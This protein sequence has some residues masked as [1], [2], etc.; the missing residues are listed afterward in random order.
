[1][2]EN[3]AHWLLLNSF[4]RW[5][6]APQG[7]T[8]TWNRGSD[9]LRLIV[10]RN[11]NFY[12]WTVKAIR[13]FKKSTISWDLPDAFGLPQRF[14]TLVRPDIA[15]CFI[16]CYF[17]NVHQTLS[18][19]FNTL[20]MQFSL[21]TTKRFSCSSGVERTRLVWSKRCLR[22]IFVSRWT[23]TYTREKRYWKQILFQQL[24]CL[25]EYWMWILKKDEKPVFLSH[26]INANVF[27]GV[28]STI[29][30]VLVKRS[31]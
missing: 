5:N 16:S 8:G 11:E 26:N 14:M 21:L 28:T 24:L 22:H 1:M 31:S 2:K 13:S 17:F 7:H 9:F 3:S 15:Q 30:S 19:N 27:Y 10:D 4:S 20:L 29:Y 25:C 6:Y 12:E 18:L 23:V